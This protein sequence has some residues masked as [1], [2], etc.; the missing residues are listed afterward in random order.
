MSTSENLNDCQSGV[1]I[2]PSVGE[3]N[4]R[5]P[6]T[7]PVGVAG[8][9]PDPLDPFDPASLRI[10]Q[11]FGANLGVKKALITVPVRKPSNESFVQVHPDAEFCINTCVVELKE[12]REV[13]LVHQ[14]LWPELNGE[15]T[16][17]PRALFTTVT[18]QGVVFLWPIR[19]PGPDGKIDSWNE[20]AMEAANQARGRWVRV[21]ANMCLGAYDVFTALA[22]MPPPTWP[23]V[24]FQELLRVAFKGKF[25]GTMDHIVLKKLRGEM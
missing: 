13:Y 15:A 10:S 4:A 25:I 24:S 19:L 2:S 5:P 21:A 8:T 1:P 14:S 18:R 3:G 20:A 17:G 11:D 12:E 6:G 16:F 9:P 22:E 7:P 23:D